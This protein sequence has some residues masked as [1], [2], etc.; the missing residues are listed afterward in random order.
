MKTTEHRREQ[1]FRDQKRLGVV[2][3]E[4]SRSRRAGTEEILRRFAAED[5]ERLAAAIGEAEME[6]DAF[7]SRLAPDDE[8]GE[9]LRRVIWLLLREENWPSAI[10]ALGNVRKG[11]NGSESISASE[12]ARAV[13]RYHAILHDLEK[14]AVRATKPSA[15]DSPRRRG[16]RRRTDDLY[17]LVNRLYDALKAARRPFALEWERDRPKSFDAIFVHD[18][19]A[20]IDK[21]RLRGLVKVAARVAE[22]RRRADGSYRPRASPVS[23]N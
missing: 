10:A 2:L 8:F 18:V 6:Y 5:R 11:K 20:L 9:T 7:Q 4:M 13:A 21:R 22:A 19:V 3:D 1:A 23:R 15:F 17:A 14:I 16:P 12:S